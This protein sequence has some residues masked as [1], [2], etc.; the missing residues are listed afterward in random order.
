MQKPYLNLGSGKIILPTI[1]RPVHHALVEPAIYGYPLWHNVDR[2]MQPGVDQCV[3][4]FSY[5]WPLASDSYDGALLSHIAEHIPHE[6]RIS[7][8]GINMGDIAD[9]PEHDNMLTL[10]AQELEKCQDGWYA[11]FA[12]L[13]RVLTNGAIVHILSPYGWS[14][15]AITDPTHTRLLTEHTFT[16]SMAPDPNSPFEYNT[17]GIHFE[18]LGWTPHINEMFRHL[19]DD[20][21]EL[22]R[23][24]G[25]R[26]NVVYEMYVQLKVVK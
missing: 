7:G 4:L 2:N 18:M 5:P 26:I 21:G 24:I 14:Q 1:D 20:R 19:M 10:R 8:S 23:A 22:T 9:K 6:I 12:E 11:F 13:Y 15:G 25:T 17:A 16:H 3:D